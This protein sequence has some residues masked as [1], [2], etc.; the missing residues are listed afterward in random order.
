M[1]KPRQ[2][3]HPEFPSLISLQL[4]AVMG[5]Q[6]GRNEAAPAQMNAVTDR[7]DEMVGLTALDVA[8]ALR[9]VA[10]AFNQ[11]SHELDSVLLQLIKI[12]DEK[13]A[14]IQKQTTRK[15]NG[16]FGDFT[17]RRSDA[18]CRNFFKSLETS[19]VV[20]AMAI[21]ASKYR[22]A[23]FE[24]SSKEEARRMAGVAEKLVRVARE[25]GGSSKPDTMKLL[26]DVQMSL[27]EKAST[28]LAV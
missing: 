23:A 20:D 22:D 21:S 11:D 5:F 13:A 25:L 9:R 17:K 3:G 2:A 28:R 14:D 19:D 10:A 24:V 26:S 6:D 1:L 12:R 15:F 8:P 7:L 4:S 27:E 18:F 16:I